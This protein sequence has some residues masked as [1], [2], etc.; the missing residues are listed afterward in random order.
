MAD[1]STRAGKSVCSASIEC[2]RMIAGFPASMPEREAQ[3]AWSQ[4]HSSQTISAQAMASASRSPG[5][6][7][8]KRVS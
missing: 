1:H 5:A 4:H 8:M 2:R 6:V 7:L 3:T